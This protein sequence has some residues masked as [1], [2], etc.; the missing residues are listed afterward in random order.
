MSKYRH[1]VKTQDF[2]LGW[3]DR[4]YYKAVEA[5]ESIKSGFPR[6][7]YSMSNR[8][9]IELFYQPSTRTRISF[10]AAM[11]RMGGQVIWTENAREFSS[12][13]KGET[14]EDTIRVLDYADL[15]VVRHQDEGTVARM[16]GMDVTPV[17]NGGDG[18]GQ[19]PTQALLDV[20]TIKKELGRLNDLTIGLMGDL[21]YGRTIHSLV[22]LLAKYEPRLLFFIS[23]PE[24]PMPGDIIAYLDR[25][26]VSYEI[27]DDVRTIAGQLDVLYQTRVQKEYFEN[28][29]DYFRVASRQIVDK[30]LMNLLPESSIVMHPLPRVGEIDP[31]IDSD[32]RAAYFRQARNGLY[33]RMALINWVLRGWY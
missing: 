17:I 24:L 8:I 12:A 21:K 15:V 19:H 31:A 13:A 9:M 27:I 20:W 22:Y 26:N 32:Y 14:P 11:M 4:F 33:V 5:E 3:L 1:I 25:H 10:A 16:A 2:D 28:E 23:P 30:S 7:F 29:A 6:S 18:I